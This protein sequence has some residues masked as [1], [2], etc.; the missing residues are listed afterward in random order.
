MALISS[1]HVG[2]RVGDI[3]VFKPTT[4]IIGDLPV[5]ATRA[6]ASFRQTGARVICTLDPSA[7]AKGGGSLVV[8]TKSFTKPAYIVHWAG[9]RTAED[10]T[11]CGSSAD[12]TMS[13]MD[14]QVA[15]QRHRR[16]QPQQQRQ[17]AVRELRRA[18]QV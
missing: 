1:L 11:S 4:N 17:R 5:T 2:L 15:G 7:M 13:R 6:E 10:G 9:A 16:V 3:L 8:E 18:P 14:L 12:L